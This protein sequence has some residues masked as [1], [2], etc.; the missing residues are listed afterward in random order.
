[1][2]ERGGEGGWD[3]A[4]EYEQRRMNRPQGGEDR[5]ENDEL[6]MNVDR[7]EE[8]SR[9]EQTDSERTRSVRASAGRGTRGRSRSSSGSSSG[10]Y[11]SS[12]GTNM[13]QA[14]VAEV[15]GTFI[16]VYAGTAVAVAASLERPI[17]G[18]SYD[19]LSVALAFGL[20]LVALVAALGHVSGAHFNPAVTLSLAVTKKFP[21]NYVP[22]YLIAQL[23]G[24]ILGAIATWI[25]LGGPARSD[26]F[27]AAPTLGDGVGALQ[28]FLVEALITFILVF[29]VIS[30]ATDERVSGAVAPIAV[31][32][33]LAVAVFI[34]GPVTGGSANP[35]RALGPIIVAATRFDTAIIYILAPIAGGIL[36]AVLYDHFLS[37]ADAPE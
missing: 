37:E 30:V 32:F 36:A 35:A 16:L 11:G 5:S 2:S 34:G 21:W 26:A 17:V 4:R 13:T 27:L 6:M 20:A 14:S 9:S 15:I 22:A 25:T 33:A 1:M 12:I 8:E 7:R 10:L 19:S 28:G 29:V 31:G 18:P 24:A 23:A 3:P